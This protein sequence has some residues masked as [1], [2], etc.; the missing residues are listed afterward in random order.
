LALPERKGVLLAG[1]AEA[2]VGFCI[3]ADEPNRKQSEDNAPTAR[4]QRRKTLPSLPMRFPIEVSGKQ[5][6]AQNELN[7]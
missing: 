4:A 7:D 6:P 2:A 5:H 1:F 3:D